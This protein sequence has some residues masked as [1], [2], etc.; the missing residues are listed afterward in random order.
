MYLLM[1]HAGKQQ[2]PPKTTPG[3]PVNRPVSRQFPPSGEQREHRKLGDEL[4]QPTACCIAIF[5]KYNCY[6]KRGGITTNLTTKW[7]GVLWS[8]K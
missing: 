3:T 1:N 2:L 7:V 4:W 6:T 5:N 8:S